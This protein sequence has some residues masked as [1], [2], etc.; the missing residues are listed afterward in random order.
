M[1][2]FTLVML[3]GCASEPEPQ[4]QPQAAT[5]PSAPAPQN[6]AVATSQCREYQDTVQIGNQPQPVHGLACRDPDGS[7]RIVR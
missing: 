7:W 5:P 6:K 4:A 1:I 3:A 2:G